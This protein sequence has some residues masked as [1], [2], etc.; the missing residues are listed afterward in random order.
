M[1][2]VSVPGIMAPLGSPTKYRSGSTGLH[3]ML[4]KERSCFAHIMT[5]ISVPGMNDDTV[6][7]LADHVVKEW[8]HWILQLQ[9]NKRRR[10]FPV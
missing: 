5:T 4:E 2:I 3:S 9:Q 10:S 7:K 6:S 8:G 1:A